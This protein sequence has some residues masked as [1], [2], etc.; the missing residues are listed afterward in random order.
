MANAAAACLVFPLGLIATRK[1][2]A[3]ALSL[4]PA[5]TFIGA[6]AVIAGVSLA[7]V[8]NLA[9]PY[10]EIS[11]ALVV[12]A[13][14][15]PLLP[16][17]LLTTLTVVRYGAATYFFS[18]DRTWIGLAHNIELL[19]TALMMG[20][21]VLVAL[22]KK[23]REERTLALGEAVQ[24]L[25]VHKAH[26]EHLV[27]A[28]TAEL[29]AANDELVQASLQK[30]RFLANTSHEMRT[31]LHAIL[32]FADLGIERLRDARVDKVGIYL[33]RIKDNADRLTNFVDNL[34]N[35]ARVLAGKVELAICSVDLR[36]LTY[37]TAAALEGM[38]AAKS[39]TIEICYP[40]QVPHSGWTDVQR[41]PGLHSSCSQSS[42]HFRQHAHAIGSPV[43]RKENGQGESCSPCSSQCG[44]LN[45]AWEC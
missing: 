44:Q 27:K 1:S 16:A 6:A 32:A 12:A 26:L 9:I 4:G 23:K 15:M 17:V 29:R 42:R 7:A 21:P 11:T 41:S 39:Q 22:L 38:A 25:E 20:G 14:L 37:E 35:L 10:L 24:A 43:M 8:R 13:L 18:G 3:E 33:K 30:D 5:I 19:P 34:L 31:P 28:R 36:D 45:F 40:S 2:V